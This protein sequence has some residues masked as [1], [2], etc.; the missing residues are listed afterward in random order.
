MPKFKY[1]WGFVVAI[2]GN[3]WLWMEIFFEPLNALINRFAP[4]TTDED[5]HFKAVFTIIFHGLGLIAVNQIWISR[6][7]QDL[8]WSLILI[9]LGFPAFW[10]VMT[11]FEPNES[12]LAYSFFVVWAIIAVILYLWRYTNKPLVVKSQLGVFKMLITSVVLIGGILLTSLLQFDLL[13]DFKIDFESIL[14]GLYVIFL[15]VSLPILLLLHVIDL[16]KREKRLKG[17]EEYKLIETLGE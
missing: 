13:V 15:Q 11:L 12:F 10:W 5:L 1:T 17:M 16:H 4:P 2:L 9:G 7:K 3:I 8:R 14:G 6:F